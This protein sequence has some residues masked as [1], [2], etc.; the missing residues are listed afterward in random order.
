MFFF[1]LFFFLLCAKVHVPVGV[2]ED[3]I[4]EQKRLQSWRCE[5]LHLFF[6]GC[7]WKRQ[8]RKNK[9][10]AD[11]KANI[12]THVVLNVHKSIT[13]ILQDKTQIDHNLFFKG[14]MGK[15]R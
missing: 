13:F 7:Q 10:P 5:C 12:K 9:I 6:F 2:W 15:R 3:N 1:S 4:K 14:N 11:I 8:N